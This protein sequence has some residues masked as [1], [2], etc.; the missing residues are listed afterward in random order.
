M[1]LTPYSETVTRL[2]DAV[3]DERLAPAA[4]EAVSNYVGASGAA[5]LLVNKLTRHVSAITS[6]GSFAGSQVDYLAHYGKI[7]PFRVI[8]EEAAC[9]ELA[10]LSDRLPASVLRHDEWYNDYILKGGVCDILGTKLHENRSHMV[11]VGLHR[12]IGDTRPIPEDVEALQ[13]LMEPLRN[14]ARLHLGLISIGFRSAIAR[15]RLNHLHAGVVFT[16]GSSRIIE[17]NPAGEAI[18]RRGDGL[19]MHGGQICARRSFETTKLARLIANATAANESDF[20]AGCMLI[21]RDFGL[22]SYV[23]RV[24]PV[25]NRSAGYDL[26]VAMIVVSAPKENLISERELADLYG[27]SPAESR[28]AVALARGKR[29]NQLPSELG[30]QI[31]TL[32]TQL[33]SVLR[34]CEVERQ[35]DLVRLIASIPVIQPVPGETERV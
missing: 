28:L 32:R 14:A 12:A 9:G 31:T 25:R 23:V 24:A 1:P 21:A 11:I 20:S 6:W 27:L 7:D 34:K 5:Y 29:M 19:T 15:G 17:A 3:L 30:V 16:D 10:R 2:F 35:I 22:P 13:M 33:S 4:L 26:P 8:Q 18:L